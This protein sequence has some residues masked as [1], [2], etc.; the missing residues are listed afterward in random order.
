[1]KS[2]AE[3]ADLVRQQLEDTPDTSA[4]RHNG[5]TILKGRRKA[6]HWHYGLQDLRELMDFIYDGPPDDEKECI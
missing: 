1:M 4:G 6:H 2:R 5:V 3:V